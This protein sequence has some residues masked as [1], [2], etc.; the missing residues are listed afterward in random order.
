MN[1]LQTNP[2]I[3]SLEQIASN[4][5]PTGRKARADDEEDAGK[6]RQRLS[7]TSILRPFALHGTA[8]LSK[9]W[10]V[11][12]AAVRRAAQVFG[13]K[14][15]IGSALPGNPGSAAADFVADG[16]SSADRDLVQSAARASAQELAEKAREIASFKLSPTLLQGEGRQAYA[17]LHLDDVGA[18]LLAIREQH[19]AK[20]AKLR[21]AAE[22]VAAQSGASVDSVMSV[23]VAGEDDRL[24]GLIPLEVLDLG[25]EVA[26]LDAAAKDLELGYCVMAVEAL[27]TARALDDLAFESLVRQK[28]EIHATPEMNSLI[29]E[30]VESVVLH[31]CASQDV[32]L[33][34][35]KD[36]ASAE[37]PATPEIKVR[38]ENAEK[39]VVTE[40]VPTKR[41]LSR[42]Q[43]YP[44]SGLE[45]AE[46]FDE[47]QAA[48]DADEVQTVVRE[49]FVPG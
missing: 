4:Q 40:T 37:E 17:A 46:T 48:D 11:I 18:R 29:W 6:A 47:D 49:R 26:Q 14:A 31:K 21:Q 32:H 19:E 24:S 43:R 3:D 36:E 23:L 38:S 33:Q 10:Q 39:V 44:A 13:V 7:L 25:K 12:V 1:T 5:Y 2:Q 28:V 27:S 22:V 41:A 20:L 45:P 35:E 42:A 30:E 9:L 15:D 16:N 8:F 34:T